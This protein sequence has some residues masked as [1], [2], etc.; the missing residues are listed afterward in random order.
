MTDATT[1][2]AMQIIWE[3]VDAL[4]EVWRSSAATTAECFLDACE[5][6]I[7][8]LMLAS[9]AFVFHQ[10]WGPALNPH[11]AFV[12]ADPND[13]LL[14]EPQKQIGAYRADFA[15]THRHA[16]ATGMVCEVRAVVECDGHAFHEKT[17]E[18]AIRD[19]TRDREMTSEG[20]MVLR[21]SGR[22][23]VHNPRQCAE[24][25]REAVRKEHM[26]QV[27]RFVESL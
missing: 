21:F 5:S 2:R 17:P 13:R 4:L 3:D 24:T 19:K 26:R 10:D 23:I 12:C 9:L 14:I 1:E 20:W 15:I 7:E 18:Q 25:V 11:P 27:H 22:E 6:P 16:V 8:K